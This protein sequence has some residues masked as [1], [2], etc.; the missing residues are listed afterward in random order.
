MLVYLKVSIHYNVS[1]NNYS[2]VSNVKL[3]EI[4][5]SEI[6]WASCIFL[7]SQV[8]FSPLASNT[9]TPSSAGQKLEMFFIRNIKQN[10]KIKII[11]KHYSTYTCM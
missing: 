4:S 6:T 5:K 11:Q 1:I 7:L 2:L 9:S 10:L 3:F 8:R